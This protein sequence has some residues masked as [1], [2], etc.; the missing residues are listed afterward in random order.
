GATLDGNHPRQRPAYSA[1]CLSAYAGADATSGPE[2]RRTISA[3][4]TE[5]AGAGRALPVDLG[6][7]ARPVASGWRIVA[8]PRPVLA[9]QM[10][11]GT[12][13]AAHAAPWLASSACRNHPA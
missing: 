1:V 4:E 3:T 5:P 13:H 9:R 7:R 6:Q 12:R 8:R 10:A 11:A 2:P